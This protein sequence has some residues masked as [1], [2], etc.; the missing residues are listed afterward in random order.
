MYWISV[1]AVVRPAQAK[2]Q[3]VTGVLIWARMH[4]W[5]SVSRVNVTQTNTD[6]AGML[7]SRD[8]PFCRS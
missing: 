5:V 1:W 8:M 3:N 2:T 7:H 4:N 6:L